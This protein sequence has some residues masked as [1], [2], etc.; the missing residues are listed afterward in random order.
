MKLI[1]LAAGKGTRF[2]PTTNTTPK[3]MVPV[4]GEPLLKH[5]VTPYLPHVSDIIFVINNTP[6]SNQIKDCFKESYLGHN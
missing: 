2:L 6:L 4:L 5:V 1:I 3:G